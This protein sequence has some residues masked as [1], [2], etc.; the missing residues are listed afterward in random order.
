MAPE[1]IFY[2]LSGY[3]KAVYIQVYTA[4][5]YQ[6]LHLHIFKVSYNIRRNFFTRKDYNRGN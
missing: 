1:L 2:R 3:T 5:Y 4:F 6:I